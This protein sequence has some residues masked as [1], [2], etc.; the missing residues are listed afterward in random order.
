[1]H[2]RQHALFLEHADKQNIVTVKWR[3]RANYTMKSAKAR[4]ESIV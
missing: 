2:S 3:N 1:M 4:I